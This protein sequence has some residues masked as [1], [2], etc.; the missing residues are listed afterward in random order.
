M[1]NLFLTSRFFLLFGANV[2]FFVLA[3]PFPVF[4]V[5]AQAAL[6]FSLS[7]VLADGWLLYRNDGLVEGSRKLPRVMSLGDPLSVQ[8]ETRNISS[9]PLKISLI[10]ELPEQFQIRDFV[11]ALELQSGE[12]KRSVYSLRPTSRG[13][14]LFGAIHYFVSTALGLLQRRV[15]LPAEEKLPVYPSIIQMRK[16]E[17]GA[18]QPTTG[19][20]GI[21]RMR[22]LGHSYEFE[23]IKSYVRGDDYR[24]INWK[25][26]GRRGALMVNQFQDERSQQVYC[27]IDKSRSM[28]LPFDGLSLMDHSINAALAMSNLV[29][30]K[31]DKAGLLTFSDKIGAVIKADRKANQLHQILHALYK[32]EENPLEVNFELAYFAIQKFIKRRSLLLLFTNFESTYALDRVLPI[33]RKLSRTHLLIVV[34]FRNTE[35]EAFTK[36]PVR[37]VEE[38]YQQTVARQFIAEKEQMV[39]KLKQY[40]IQAILTRPDELAVSSA[41]KYLELKA[42]GLI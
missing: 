32:E 13:E 30:K 22:R 17:L 26:S 34:F 38:I 12:R 39:Q 4:F 35:V 31:H 21:K 10:D 40:G 28:K 7:L 24:S 1:K 33:L 36:E 2:L 20:S 3:F 11:I 14:Y 6:V 41:N 5:P 9:L 18:F 16:L 37:T 27:L 42:R 8:L 19:E 25:A 29:L 15:S 23:H